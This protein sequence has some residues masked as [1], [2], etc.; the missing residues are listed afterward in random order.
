[1]T[2]NI[3]FA[4]PL[5]RGKKGSVTWTMAIAV[6]LVTSTVILAPGGKSAV[7]LSE[8]NNTTQAES[9]KKVNYICI[10][11]V[12]NCPSTKVF[13]IVKT[14]QCTCPGP[15]CGFQGESSILD[16]IL[17][18]LLESIR[19]KPSSPATKTSVKNNINAISKWFT[20]EISTNIGGTL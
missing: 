11:F 12:C 15:L 6:R 10:L 17:I 7:G 9:V 4:T 8:E 1:M 19:G 3:T 20:T 16:E 5:G 13:Y 2:E 18:Y 14:H